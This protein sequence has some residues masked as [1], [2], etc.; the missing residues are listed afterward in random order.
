MLRVAFALLI[1]LAFVPL[2]SAEAQE[3]IPFCVPMALP[4]DSV[5]DAPPQYQDFCAR[6]PQA[7]DMAGPI[8]VDWTLERHG[9]L[10]EVNAGVNRDVLFT[11]DLEQHGVEERWYL[12]LD[13]RGDCEDFALEKRERLV[14]LGWPRASLTMAFAYHEVQFFPHA[15]LLAETTQGTWVLDNLYNEVRCWDGVPYRYTFREQ[16]DGNWRRFLQ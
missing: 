5:V 12:P 2:S 1:S 15:V 3:R 16:A 7:C 11:S 14:A 8:V 13:C 6:T 10:R 4:T 9:Q